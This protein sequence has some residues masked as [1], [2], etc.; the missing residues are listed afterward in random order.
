MMGV[1]QLKYGWNGPRGRRWNGNSQD[2]EIIELE[3]WITCEACCGEGSTE[4]G[5]PQPDDPYFAVTIKCE[6]CN[7]S[8]WECI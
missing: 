7:G 1:E 4:E 8:G 3:Q 2:W 5:R 6:L